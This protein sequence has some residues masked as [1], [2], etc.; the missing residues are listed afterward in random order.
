MVI[1]ND[2]QKSILDAID[3]LIDNRLK[4]LKFNRT[5]TGKITAI[6]LDNTY[7]V[8]INGEISVLKAREDLILLV[9]DIVYVEIPNNN[10]SF[11]YINCKRP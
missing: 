4:Y 9:D 5:T 3:Y 2:I 10:F 11:A 8:E 6:N 7:N 1:I